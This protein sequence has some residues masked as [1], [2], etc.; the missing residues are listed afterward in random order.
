MI[1][2]ICAV[3]SAVLYLSPQLLESCLS[4]AKLSVSAQAT[5]YIGVGLLIVFVVSTAT[6]QPYLAMTGMLLFIAG[7]Y[8][9]Q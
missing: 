2:V 1:P 6:I 4:K 3:L 9:R 8:H 7:K 5:E